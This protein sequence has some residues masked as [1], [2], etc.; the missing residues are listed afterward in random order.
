MTRREL[1][2]GTVARTQSKCGARTKTGRS[3]QRLAM[4]GSSRCDLHQG[5]WSAYAVAKRKAAEAKK[6]GKRRRK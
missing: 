4:K 2:G 6:A 5:E 3:C 1:L